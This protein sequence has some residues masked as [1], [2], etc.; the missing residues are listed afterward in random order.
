MGKLTE[1]LA[2]FGL[3][4]DQL[5]APSLSAIV[6]SMVYGAFQEG[7]QL[8]LTLLRDASPSDNCV[9]D[10]CFFPSLARRFVFAWRKKKRKIHFFFPHKIMNFLMKLIYCLKLNIYAFFKGLC[11]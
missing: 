11:L 4:G 3:M 2:S 8:A 6:L 7:P 1:V 9:P 10:R 5:R